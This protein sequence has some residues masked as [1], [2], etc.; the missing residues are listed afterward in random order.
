MNGS[1]SML[2]LHF[3][4][5]ELRPMPGAYTYALGKEEFERHCTFFASMRASA[6]PK[7]MQPEITFD[8][9][10]TSDIDIA[11]PLL[12]RHGLRATF[13]ITA[14]WTGT[15][16][17]Y[18]GW[19]QLRRL[20]EAGHRLGAHGMTH[21]LLPS[22]TAAELTDELGGAKKRLEDGLGAAVDLLSLPGGR[23]DRQVLNQAKAAGYRQVFTSVPDAVRL[24]GAPWLVGR[25]NLLT[26]TDVTWLQRALDPGSGL[27]TRLHRVHA[28]KA[29]GQRM[30]G[31]KNYARLWALI[32]RQNA[33]AEP[34][35]L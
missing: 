20:R 23:A 35:A 1:N 6:D 22:C 34:E 32:N 30:L 31:N 29:M 12:E 11:M 27:L 33:D 15:R 10:H 9:G 14:G 21:K 28:A 17:G 7:Q 2:S 18:M 5:H 8:D 4:Y 24:D 16:Q 26:G 13:F 25:L 3:L 19:P